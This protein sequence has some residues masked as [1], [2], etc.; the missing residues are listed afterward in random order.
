[1]S[2]NSSAPADGGE[3]RV[4][5]PAS[6][7]LRSDTRA[8]LSRYDGSDPNI[9]VLIAY[10]GK[11]Y[12]VTASFPWAKGT[13]WDDVRAGEDLTGRLKESIHGEEMLVRVPCIWDVGR[14][15]GPHARHGISPR[16]RA[17]PPLCS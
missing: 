11:V 5:G 6:V 2:A 14:L 12:D 10:K 7:S 13:H 16:R 3:R 15:T 9:P 8:Q 1:M 17:S 4:E